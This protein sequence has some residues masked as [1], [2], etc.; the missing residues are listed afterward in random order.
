[1]NPR[2]RSITEDN[3]IRALLINGSKLRVDS[4]ADEKIGLDVSEIENVEKAFRSDPKNK[5]KNIPGHI[6]TAVRQKPL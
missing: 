1:M 3:A 4:A 2:Q 5:T 6:Y